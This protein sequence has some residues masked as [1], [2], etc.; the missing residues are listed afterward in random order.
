MRKPSE[1]AARKVAARKVCFG[2]AA[3]AT[4]QMNEHALAPLLRAPVEAETK[5]R[6]IANHTVDP[7]AVFPS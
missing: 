7:P 5:M 2:K 3:V 4:H 1:K 6:Q